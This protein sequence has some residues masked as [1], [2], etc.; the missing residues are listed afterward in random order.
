MLAGVQNEACCGDK[1]SGLAGDLCEDFGPMIE[2][3]PGWL[4]YYPELALGVVD[5]GRAM[6][7]G[8]PDGPTATR[9]VN[10]VVDIDPSSEV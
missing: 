6:P 9:E 2:W 7:S 1:M 3:A 4:G 10:L 5:G 8:G